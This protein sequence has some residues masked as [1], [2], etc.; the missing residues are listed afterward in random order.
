M[1]MKKGGPLRPAYLIDIIYGTDRSR[2]D[3][4]LRVKQ[5]L[6]QLSYD[7][8]FN[9]CSLLWFENLCQDMSAGGRNNAHYHSRTF[10]LGVYIKQKVGHCTKL[11]N[12]VQNFRSGIRR[13]RPDLRGVGNEFVNTRR[14][15]DP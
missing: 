15:I 3:D 2:T 4:L 11:N 1:D 12:S 8:K 9:S 14:H 7:P 13:D 6:F 5:A 10:A